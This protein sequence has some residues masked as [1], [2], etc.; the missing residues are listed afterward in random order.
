MDKNVYGS[1][2]PVGLVGALALATACGGSD[3]ETLSS[4]MGEV[5]MESRL[6]EG[7]IRGRLFK[8]TA[9]DAT[10]IA[11]EYTAATKLW[12]LGSPSLEGAAAVPL[13]IPADLRASNQL[14]EAAWYQ[15]HPEEERGYRS[16]TNTALLYSCYTGCG[17]GAWYAPV[18]LCTAD[19]ERR[20]DH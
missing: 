9:P 7:A 2:F 12:R 8:A 1:K 14:L 5:V 13:P 18:E 3:A 10:L 11:T 4:A 6:E 20:F 19:C 17:W 16:V 15:L